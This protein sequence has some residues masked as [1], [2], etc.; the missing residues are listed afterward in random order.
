MIKSL[1]N[2]LF[3]NKRLKS[4]VVVCGAQKAG[5]SA[6]HFYLRQLP[7][8]NESVLGKET[9]FFMSDKYLKKG[10]NW[11]SNTFKNNANSFYALDSTPDYSYN[12]KALIKIKRFG[13]KKNVPLKIILIL[14]DPVNRA[15]SAYNMFYRHWK[16][17]TI[18]L[19]RLE[20][21]NDEDSAFL[22]KTLNLSEFPSFSDCI[23]LEVETNEKEP[24]FLK[25]GLYSKQ[26]DILKE[27]FS[28]EKQFLNNGGKWFSHV[29][30]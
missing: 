14:R 11:F 27:I 26:I 7:E 24:S 12:Y 21:Y 23:R 30:L 3:F 4:L 13:V 19:K 16:E 5:T 2:R 18:S 15:L 29:T 17:N 1:K 9:A 6:L 20:R 10:F 22:K 8:L 25:R 28:K